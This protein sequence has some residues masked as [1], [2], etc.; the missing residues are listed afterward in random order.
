MV[1]DLEPGTI[2]AVRSGPLGRMFKPDNYVHAHRGAGGNWAKGHYM[3][4]AELVD[5]ILDI[6]RKEAESCDRLQGMQ[7]THAIGGGTGSGLGT[8]TMSKIQEEYPDRMM[9]YFSVFPSK[10]V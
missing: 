7:L 5:T 1:I 9:S 6:V 3:E 4:G 2:D 8:L 10:K